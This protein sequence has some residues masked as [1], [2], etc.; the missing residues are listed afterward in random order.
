[1][2]PRF[3]QLRSVF[4]RL[5]QCTLPYGGYTPAKLAQHFDV[6]PVTSNIAHELVLPELPVGLWGCCVPATF[7]P[8]PETTM[9]ENDGSV[10]WKDE[11]RSAGQLPVMKSI[12]QSPGKKKQAQGPF[13]PGVLS[14][15]ARHHAAALLSGRY[16]HGPGDIR[17]GYF[18][19][20][21]LDCASIRQSVC[22]LGKVIM[23]LTGVRS[24]EGL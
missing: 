19:R 7:V 22:N 3:H 24:Q 10:L 14:A 20:S 4:G 8:M 13:W 23:N 17:L 6:S 21:P 5:F 12:A 11:V 18:R 15:D 1:M 2:Q 9:D 16:T